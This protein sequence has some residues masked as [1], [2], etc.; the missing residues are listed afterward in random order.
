MKNLKKGFTLIELMIV[1]AIIAILAV[2][3]APKFGMQLRKAKD[4]RAIA[5]ITTY[6]SALTMNASDNDGNYA[7]AFQTLA[8]D[9]DKKTIASTYNAALA[10]PYTES[11]FT[12]ASTIGDE[13]TAAAG[14]STLLTASNKPY[15]ILKIS[16]TITE[17]AI[18]FTSGAGVD[19]KNANWTSY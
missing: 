18:D 14:T 2:V 16:G 11:T 19:S 17:S 10:T 4:S 5:L 12:T 1:V 3:A 8:A 15:V 9:V 7:T 13:V 6:R